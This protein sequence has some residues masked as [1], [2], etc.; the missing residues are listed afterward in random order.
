M[1]KPIQQTV[2]QVPAI[3]G[4][5]APAG[6]DTAEDRHHGIE[7]GN[8]NTIIGAKE[9]SVEPLTAPQIE[10]TPISRPITILP[11]SPR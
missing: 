3:G 2:V 5:D 10:I 1:R 8:V 6:Q 4:K 7:S 11:A 9:T